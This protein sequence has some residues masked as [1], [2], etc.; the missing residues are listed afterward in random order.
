MAFVNKNILRGIDVP[1]FISS[2]TNSFVK[3]NGCSGLTTIYSLNTTPPSAAVNNRYEF[4]DNSHYQN[5]TLY[6]PKEALNAYKTADVWKKFLNIQGTD[7]TRIKGIEAESSSKQDIYYDL[8]GHRLYAP[9][10]G[11]NI[12]NGKKVVVK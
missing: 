2:I 4:F 1:F 11:L 3:F 8:N 5:A 6:V 7:A 9:K 12:I 10:K